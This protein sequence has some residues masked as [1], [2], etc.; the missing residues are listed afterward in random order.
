[1][2]ALQIELSDLDLDALIDRYLP[3]LQE[4]LRASGNP[5]GMLLSNGMPTEMAKRVLHSLSQEAKEQLC[6]DLINGNRGRIARKLEEQAA[7]N[8][9]HLTVNS[10]SAAQKN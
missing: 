2:I 4:Q 8:G 5:V 10:L 1:M 9:F 3:S 6:A 7:Q